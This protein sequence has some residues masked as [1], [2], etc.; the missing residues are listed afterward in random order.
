MVGG[1]VMALFCS[2]VPTVEENV[3]AR[4]IYLLPTLFFGFVVRCDFAASESNYTC[5]CGGD[6]E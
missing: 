5:I 1:E 2:E 6:A 4:E 3:L